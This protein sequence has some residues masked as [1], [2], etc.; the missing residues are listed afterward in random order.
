[1]GHR[2][3]TLSSFVAD[4]IAA[5][6][7]VERPAS[8]IKEL[9]E[10]AVDA[11]ASQVSVSL[12]QGGIKRI[13]VQ[14]NGLG[15]HHDDLGLALSRH[16][17]SKINA[18][19]DL[20]EIATLGF[21]GEALASIAS[22]SRL[23]L[24]SA[25]EE[26]PHAW[27]VRVR[28]GEVL[29]IEP[30]SHTQGTSVEVLDIFYNTPVRR[31]FLKTER[32]ELNHIEDVFDRLSLAHMGV[33]L[34]LQQSNKVIRRL[35]AADNETGFNRRLSVVLG[36]KFV[37]NS[38]FL[39][40][41][42]AG[43]RLYGWVGLPTFS[44]SHADKQFF[45]VNGRAVRDKLVAHAI[46][47]AYRDVLFHGRHPV[48]V[49]YLELDAGGVDVNVHP[50]KHEVRFREGRSVHDFIFGILNKV[51]RDL[52][53]ESQEMGHSVE[54]VFTRTAEGCLLRT[55]E[56][57]LPGAAEGSLPGAAEGSQGRLGLADVR[58]P[59]YSALGVQGASAYT[60]RVLDSPFGHTVAAGS[61]QESGTTPP[62]GYAIAQ[63]HGVYI[64][65]QNEEGLVIV[66]MHAAHERLTYEKM[67]QQRS[68]QIRQ[69]LLVPVEVEVTQQEADQVEDAHAFLEGLG[70]CVDR[71]APTE[72]LV[73]EIPALLMNSDVER[74]LRDVL[75]DLKLYGQSAR[76]LEHQDDMLATLACHT[77]IRANRILSLEEMNALLREMEQT[78]NSGQCNH[79]RP[80]YVTR[81]IKE[82]DSLFL[83]GQ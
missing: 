44:R 48:F 3:H 76:M 66:D 80:T 35:E 79:G 69:R 58:R 1:M 22:V 43:I 50:T 21:R 41:A 59:L 65:A 36:N 11:Q 49:L 53:P 18:A 67:K 68:D 55:A 47:Q 15:I 52:R 4:Q 16:A 6:E 20:D 32:T 82:L 56:G 73:R 17:T 14:D 23:T 62:M 77:S 34:E 25:F 29:E 45:Y 83:R 46:R 40:E 5:G 64:L 74:M 26:E 2:I 61:S 8:I 72:L 19:E 30:A 37:A 70:L 63:L 81:S 78:E 9:L 54:G 75:A 39:D 60:G 24:T 71:V 10:N 27:R 57:S 38:V 13:L 51:L 31:K 42:R 12:E 7:V 28:Q 33:G